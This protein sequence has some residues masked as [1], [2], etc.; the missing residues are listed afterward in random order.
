ML[1]GIGRIQ[2]NTN[3]LLRENSSSIGLRNQKDTGKFFQCYIHIDS[4]NFISILSYLNTYVRYIIKICVGFD[5]HFIGI[6][7]K[8][9]DGGS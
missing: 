7:L 4:F 5:F 1:L 2:F 3:V 8:L 6:F 9:V